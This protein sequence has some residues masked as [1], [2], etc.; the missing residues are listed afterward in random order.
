[1]SKGCILAKLLP[2]RCFLFLLPKYVHYLCTYNALCKEIDK[3]G[4]LPNKISQS[5][6]LHAPY[7]RRVV[8]SSITVMD[9]TVLDYVVGL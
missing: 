2:L 5:A 9:Y 4:V 8:K 6:I 7:F 1:M 3:K